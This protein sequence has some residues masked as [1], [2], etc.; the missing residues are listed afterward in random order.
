VKNSQIDFDDPQMQ[1]ASVRKSLFREMARDIVWKDRN[2]RKYGLA[3]DTGGSIA[4]AMEQA[5]K[6]GFSQAK[7]DKQPEPPKTVD[8]NAPLLWTTLPLRARD[9][10]DSIFRFDW[11]VFLVP[12]P[13]PFEVAPEVWGCFW[14]W[15]DRKPDTP[16]ELAR[17]YSMSTLKHLI[18]RGLMSD[19]EA[20]NQIALVITEKGR[21][22]WNLGLKNGQVR[23]KPIR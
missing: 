23:P 4:R 21:D 1:V 9:A 17:T 3:Q 16:I 19:I 7:S 11:M 14:D 22:T 13:K 12:N 8:T 2:S 5:Y 6:L 10:L 15:G 18:D 20:G